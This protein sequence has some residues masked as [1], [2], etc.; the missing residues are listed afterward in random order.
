MMATALAM[1]PGLITK[2]DGDAVDDGRQSGR[3][4]TQRMGGADKAGN[5]DGVL[6]AVIEWACK[7]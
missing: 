4:L 7:L 5:H 1:N 3:A 6:A 2:M